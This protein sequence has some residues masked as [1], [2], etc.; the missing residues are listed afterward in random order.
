MSESRVPEGVNY[1][2]EVWDE[3][4]PEDVGLDVNE[5]RRWLSRQHPSGAFVA[6]ERHPGNEWGA[7]IV[8]RG[9][10]VQSWGDPDYRYNSASVGKCFIRLCLQIA[11]D[12]GL[13]KDANDPVHGYWTGE[14]R[15]NH[16]D[17]VLDAGHHRTLTFRHLLTMTGGFPV[18]NGCFWR[19]GDHPEWAD[20]HGG[21][22]DRANYA[23]REPGT[24][25]YYSSGGFWRCAQ[26][27][28]RIFGRELKDVLDETLFS[29]M[30][31]PPDRWDILTG[32]VLR[33]TADFY[34]EWPGYGEFVDPPFEIDGNRVQGGGGW[35]VM[36]A[37]DLARVGLLLATGGIWKG[38]RLIGDTEF[39]NRGQGNGP[40][41]GWNGG[42]SSTLSAW[43][44]E[45]I[46]VIA[47]VAT[48]GLNWREVPFVGQ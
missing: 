29:R 16:P 32:R 7:V 40:I 38:E 34:P 12:R 19:R 27:L 25:S 35:V 15:L 8:R 20:A 14:G 17:K 3:A 47:A 24:E 26:A 6:G 37:H 48:A 46:T 28:T 23:Q 30:G 45:A 5:W 13:V 39:V 10:V 31:I 36:S 43:E 42:N 21:D 44:G 4:A 22:P 9:C 41:R 11:I 18:S 1:P 2:G 33:E